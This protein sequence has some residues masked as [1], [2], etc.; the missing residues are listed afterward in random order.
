VNA[1]SDTIDIIEHL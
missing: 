1:E